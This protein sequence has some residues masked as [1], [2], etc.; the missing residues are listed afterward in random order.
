MLRLAHPPFNS[1]DTTKGYVEL[2][3]KLRPVY[4]SYF[5]WPVSL[6]VAT[7]VSGSKQW[8]LEFRPF[9]KFAVTVSFFWKRG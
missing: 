4:R 9:N 7:E 3:E 5:L 8:I 1:L 2:I 6:V